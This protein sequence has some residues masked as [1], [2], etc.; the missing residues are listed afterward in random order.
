MAGSLKYFIYDDDFGGEW[1]MERDESNLEAVIVDPTAV[2]VTPA[3]VSTRQYTI[4]KNIKPR[5][6]TYKSTTTVA[7]RRVTIPTLALYQ[8]L[9]NSV[10]ANILRQF[11]DGGETFVLSGVTPERIKP[12]VV[13][14][15][16]GLTDGDDT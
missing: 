15:D 12:V 6:A 16:T 2:D 3:N 7:V 13:A 1:A 8:D 9:V 5:V 11:T 10:V 4:P 14:E